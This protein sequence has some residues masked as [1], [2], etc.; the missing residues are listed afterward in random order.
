MVIPIC[1]ML[2]LLWSPVT[3]LRTWESTDIHPFLKPT[4]FVTNQSQLRSCNLQKCLRSAS[5][6]SEFSLSDHS[7]CSQAKSMRGRKAL[8]QRLA[9]GC[10]SLG[11]TCRSPSGTML[12]V[13]PRFVTGSPRIEY[14]VKRDCISTPV[15]YIRMGSQQQARHGESLP[16]NG[17]VEKPHE[18]GIELIPDGLRCSGYP[19][20]S[21][22]VQESGPIW[23]YSS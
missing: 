4:R 7:G 21:A 11:L 12:S 18:P 19:S 8:V 6:E 17:A 20:H 3:F 14:R 2:T 15:F 10:T 23:R 22:T 9:P 5:P 16:A 13:A 1:G